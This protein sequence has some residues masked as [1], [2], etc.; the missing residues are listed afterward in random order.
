MSMQTAT[1]QLTKATKTL[2]YQ[3]NQATELWDDPVSRRI[4]E[5]HINPILGAVNSAIRAMESIGESVTKAQS[6]CS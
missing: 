6:D 3:W 5:K 4:E 1:A 2:K